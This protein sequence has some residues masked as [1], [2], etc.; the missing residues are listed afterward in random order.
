MG[1]LEGLGAAINIDLSLMGNSWKATG[2]GD[3]LLIGPHVRPQR[4]TGNSHTN[5]TQTSIDQLFWRINT[6]NTS[7]SQQPL[8]RWPALFVLNQRSFP[9]NWSPVANRSLGFLFDSMSVFFGSESECIPLWPELLYPC[10]LNWTNRHQTRS[11]M[12]LYNPAF[13]PSRRDF[14]DALLIKSQVAS[15][16]GFLWDSNHS[17]T[18]EG[19]GCFFF[20]LWD[21]PRGVCLKIGT[22]LLK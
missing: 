16:K 14:R 2:F 1:Y 17:V 4:C 6:W 20:F 3:T 11:E 22:F 19:R 18:C 13:Q 9:S 7:L 21:A 8:V 5:V 15:R 10:S 12:L